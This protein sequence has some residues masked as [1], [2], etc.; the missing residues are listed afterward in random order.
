MTTD[1]IVYRLTGRE[2]VGYNKRRVGKSSLDNQPS[3]HR[4]GDLDAAILQYYNPRIV[5]DRDR[6]RMGQDSE[7][8][9]TVIHSDPHPNTQ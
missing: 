6:D 1:D 5:H 4:L 2:T 3:I 9:R 7:R 8:H